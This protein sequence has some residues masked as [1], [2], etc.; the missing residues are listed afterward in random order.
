MYHRYADQ[1]V[2]DTGVMITKSQDLR[3]QI[4]QWYAQHSIEM[5]TDGS[6]V[7]KLG[8]GAADIYE[9]RLI[10]SNKVY[11]VVAPAGAL[12]SSYKSEIVGVQCGLDRLISTEAIIKEDKSIIICTDSQSLVAALAKGPITQKIKPCSD[13]WSSCLS[14]IDIHKVYN[15]TFQFIKSHV[16]VLKNERVD[17]SCS[18]ALIKYSKEKLGFSQKNLLFYYKELRLK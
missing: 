18:E 11:R 15:I 3:V 4:V 5:F 10:G 9:Q 1:D 2:M 14:L 13:I 17:L 16:G 6:V 8:A 12:C 7:N